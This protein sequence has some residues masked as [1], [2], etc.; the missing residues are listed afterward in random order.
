MTQTSANVDPNEI[1]K[2]ADLAHLW[3]DKT[4]EFKP[5]HSINPLRLSY[6]QQFSELQDQSVLDVGCGGGILSE[7]LAK[8]GANVTGIDLAEASLNVAQLHALE[9]ELEIDYEH[10][11]AEDFAESHPAKFDVVT[12]LEMLEH[13]PDPSSIVS[14]CAALVKP[15]GKVYFSTLNRNPKSWAFAIAGAEYILKLLPKGTHEFSRFIK[16]S[17]LASF[18]RSSDLDILDIT[19]MTYNPLIQN[20]KL[21]KDIDVN[22]LMACHRT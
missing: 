4:S 9:S 5:L 15:G 8:A 11:S 22:Y 14:S 20:Y 10:V 12:C 17:E 21:S 16:P 3:W 13:V 1:S 19:G 18:A 6:I 7:A 2:F